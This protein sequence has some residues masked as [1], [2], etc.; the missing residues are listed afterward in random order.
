MKWSSTLILAALALAVG[1]APGTRDASSSS[2]LTVSTK[3][4][5]VVGSLVSSQVRRWL[6]IPYAIGNR[7]EPPQ[8]APTRQSPLQANK[9]GDTCIQQIPPSLEWFQKFIGLFDDVTESEDCLYIN[10]W[11]PAV[12]RKQKTAVLIWIYGGS[13]ETGTSSSAIYNGQPFVENNDDI[14]IVSFNY[15][16]N[17]FGQPNAPQLVAPGNATN[18]GLLDRDFAIKWVYDNIAAFGGDPERITLFGQSAGGA[19]VDT[20][21]FAYPNDTMVKGL[22]EQSGSAPLLVGYPPYST[23]FGVNAW[24]N[25]SN[26]VGCG[27][28][29]TPD[30]LT[31]MKRVPFRQLENAVLTTG[32]QFQ[33]TID[34]ITT[35]ADIPARGTAGNFLRVPLLTGNTAQEM[36]IF[37]AGTDLGYPGLLVPIADEI[38]YGIDTQ[39]GFTCLSG[40]SATNWMTAGVPVWRYQYQGVFPDLTVIPGLRAYHTSD[41]PIVFGTYDGPSFPGK[42]TPNEVALSKYM[43]KAWVEFA[44]DPVH[45]LSN[46]GWPQ[47][48]PYT[49]SLVQLG[50]VLNQTGFVLAKG[51][52]GDIT[53][54]DAEAG[55]LLLEIL[56]GALWIQGIANA[57]G[58]N[59]TAR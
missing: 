18:F 41:I 4:G 33:V 13:Y 6:G 12:N 50:N 14:T 52:I 7:W 21:A 2:G 47:Y 20:Y 23:V 48:Q 8:P 24:N 45:G 5:D 55:T 58:Q 46:Y 37:R 35:F 22:I 17:I 28:D 3:Q 11:S 53:C 10:I 25:V 38:T 36:D 51:A 56:E 43:Q 9:F 27:I 15:R 29:T 16:L 26:A 30:Q 40:A 49:Q 1:A 59:S 44:R 39:L 34:N 32:A 57:A 42:S 19:S 31:C 54:T